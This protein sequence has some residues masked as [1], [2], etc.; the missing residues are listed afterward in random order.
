MTVLEGSITCQ[1]NKR[2]KMVICAG[3]VSNG[4]LEGYEIN[5]CFRRQNK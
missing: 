4:Q 5:S 1:N 2:L 3:F